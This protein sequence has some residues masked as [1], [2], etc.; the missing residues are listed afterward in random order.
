MYIICSHAA[1]GLYSLVMRVRKDTTGF[2]IVELL[3]VIV[4]I[5]ILAAITIVSYNGIRGRAEAA[6]ISSDLRN[7]AN[8]LGKQMAI[9]G[10]A[11][12]TVTDIRNAMTETK[13]TPPGGTN[14]WAI[15]LNG[16]TS[17][18]FVN[19]TTDPAQYYSS[20]QGLRSFTKDPAA[21]GSSVSA[22][23]CYQALPGYTTSTWYG[24]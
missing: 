15:C 5:A 8:T 1:C 12:P 11:F 3:I 16:T 9:D 24:S 10:T 19:S 2:T 13:I 18:A 7:I 6:A 22:K 21:P 23:M 14:G 17:F 20:V 4:V